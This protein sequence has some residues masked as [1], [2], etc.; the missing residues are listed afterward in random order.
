M[1]VLR[2]PTAR[3]RAGRM[4]LDADAAR[5]VLRVHRQRVGDSLLLFDPCDAVQAEAQ[6]VA[7]ESG[8]VELRVDDVCPS[9]A[10]PQRPVTLVQ[11]LGRAS[12]SDRVV[13][14]ATVLG[15]TRV[16]FVGSERAV[17]GERDSGGARLERWRRVAVQAARLCQRGDLPQ[18]QSLGA[19]EAV[20]EAPQL[21]TA[22]QETAAA[23]VLLELAP[24]AER[25]LSDEVAAAPAGA[26]LVL[27]VGPEGGLAPE[28]R[29]AAEI[30]GFV[31]VAL[32]PFVLPTEL[33]GAVALGVV[34]AWPRPAALPPAFTPPR[35]R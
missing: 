35:S 17:R 21:V 7:I 30:A 33:A 12:K 24:G 18:L 28:E 26:P 31:P 15:A 13:R 1:R 32:G 11:V 3:L 29:R 5:Y 23:P 16:I 4:E 10:L 27:L 14:D 22:T 34:A 6:I 25:T 9:T 2:V 19:L 20:L 8:R